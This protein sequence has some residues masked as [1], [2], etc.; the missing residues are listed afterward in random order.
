M[1]GVLLYLTNVWKILI[2]ETKG[3]CLAINL[4]NLVNS[5]RIDC[6]FNTRKN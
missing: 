5:V 2:L 1:I 6:R 4:N 3:N